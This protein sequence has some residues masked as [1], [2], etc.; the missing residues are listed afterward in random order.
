[1][2]QIIGGWAPNSLNFYED[3]TYFAGPE[4]MKDTIASIVIE[5]FRDARSTKQ[6]LRIY[7][8]KSPIRLLMQAENARRKEYNGDQIDAL[9]QAFGFCPS[10][11][12][13]LSAAKA[14]SI[15][16]WKSELVAGDPGSLVKIVPTPSPR[17]SE[18][19]K[20]QIKLEVKTE[21]MQKLMEAGVADPNYLLKLGSNKLH[22]GVEKFLKD[23]TDALRQVEQAKIVS[24]A[25][26][27]ASEIQTLMRD[28]IVEGDF[29]EAY[30]SFSD[31]QITFGIGIMRFPFWKRRVVLSDK[32]DGKGRPTRMWKTVPTFRS[33]S[34]WN[35]FPVN[36]GATVVDNSGNSEY[37]E[38]SKV[39]LV[40]LA[41]DKRYD[42]AAIERILEE[43]SFKSR[44]WLF[45]EASNTKG[46]GGNSSTYWGPEES[47]AVIYH[48]GFVTGRDLQDYGH[49]GYEPTSVYSIVAEVCCGITIRLNVLNPISAQARSFATTKFE[50]LGPGIWNTV[51][52]P[53]IL[54]DTQERLNTMLHCFE[55]NLDWA[56]R[57]PLQTNSEALRNPEEASRIVPGGKYEISDL[58]GASS[59]APDPIR[60][61][62]GPSAQYQIL[63]P[64]IQALIRQA[65]AEVG[66]PD[67]S[68]MST[69]GRGSLG[70]LSARVTQAVR[71]VRNA[72]FSEDRSMEPMLQAIFEYVI[73]ENPELVDGAD[74]DMN[75]IGV[76]GLLALEAE[77]KMKIE[78]LG[79]VMQGVQTGIAPPTVAKYAFE[80]LYKDLGIPTEALGMSDPLTD[81]AVATALSRGG[82]TPPP[83]LAGAPQLDGRSGSI[84]SVPTAIAA[85]NGAGT[86]TAGA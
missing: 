82:S 27:K 10:R 9:T 78:R 62:R 42:R 5:R 51:G 58:L 13:G 23:K 70:E 3:E 24:S 34:P 41:S 26:S 8:G 75:Y 18:A 65:D 16:D 33:V 45:P 54:H 69:F 14:K 47:A 73:D 81:N 17:L 57:P 49:T 68:D 12:Y 61:I 48:E 2:A 44:A 31:N 52:V 74:L 59:A 66:V 72:A 64:L 4:D 29:R 80:D 50:D 43:Y 32:Q 21:L 40:A 76:I 83:G 28:V 63:F 7:Q 11:F 46:E 19:S 36:D 37:Y 6:S 77:R 55:N 1:M 56:L 20:D 85:P 53:A 60:A 22:A 15:V 38:I 30:A 71:R 86:P 84:S 35:F 67:L 79:I 39:N 25:M